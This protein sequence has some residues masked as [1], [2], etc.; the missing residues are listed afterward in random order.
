[1]LPCIGRCPRCFWPDVITPGRRVLVTGAAGF[2][3]R[4][5]C[6]DLLAHGFTVRGMTRSG[7]TM[8][9]RIE[10]IHADITG[11]RSLDSAFADVGAVVHL[12]ARVHVM[13]ETAADPTAE[14]QR[15]NV[16]GTAA[17]LEAAARCQVERF[18]FASSVKAV[19]DESAAPL[20]RESTPRPS[21]PYGSSKLAAEAIVREASRAHHIQA[22]TI[23]LPLVYGPGMGG[24]MLRLFDLLDRGM[25]IPAG[26]RNSRSL[27]YAGNVAFAI[28]S[29][30]TMEVPPVGEY[31][32]SD[33]CDVSTSALMQ[34][35]ARQLERRS[36]SVPVPRAL[37]RMVE[38]LSLLGKFVGRNDLGPAVARLTGSLRVD[39]TEL[40]RAAS[41]TLPFSLEDGIRETAEWYRIR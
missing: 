30:L 18:I 36:V 4:I 10:Q 38:H 5:V 39:G 2:I 3:G 19:A 25:P 37:I 12:A 33:G 8:D 27:V 35:I 41:I 22:T 32:L 1:V 17:L 13:R 34:L 21:D 11:R 16:Q 14:F 9:S 26:I 20:T 24:N 31:F 40:P 23:R 28:R 29:L 7:R 6:D 15:V